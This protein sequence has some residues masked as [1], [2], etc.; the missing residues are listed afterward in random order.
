MKGNGA[1]AAAQT[2]RSIT[3]KGRAFALGKL[4][5]KDFAS[6]A[7]QA[8]AT[9]KRNVF[10]TW[11][12]NAEFV[13]A[14]IKPKMMTELFARM[15]QITP[16]NLPR[17]EAWQAMRDKKG[18]LVL[19]SG[20]RFLHEPTGEWVNDGD[21]LPEFKKTDYATW[22]GSTYEGMLFTAWLSIRKCT[23][24]EAITLDELKELIDEDLQLA[25]TV[26]GE[27]GDLSRQ[28]L[29]NEQP[30]ALAEKPGAT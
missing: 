13:P 21:P 9:Y 22:W 12:D 16:D 14:D 10:K 3:I 4:T 7:E 6:L 17:K 5:Y 18:E 27:I 23:G 24:Q 26:S 8:C 15:E 1:A 25:V 2:T 20:E 28:R 29:G 11:S 19:H 30:P